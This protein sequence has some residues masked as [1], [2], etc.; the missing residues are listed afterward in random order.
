M[1]TV[2]S[3][4]CVSLC[5]KTTTCVGFSSGI[6]VDAVA[7][8][9]LIFRNVSDLSETDQSRIM[10]NVESLLAETSRSAARSTLDSDVVLIA[11]NEQGEEER[12]RANSDVLRRTSQGFEGLLQNCGHKNE[13]P[14]VIVG[15]EGRTRLHSVRAVRWFLEVLHAVDA[16]RA[17]GE[18][19]VP[20]EPA[21]H[22]RTSG[23]KS[24]ATPAF[25]TLVAACEIADCWDAP[26]VFS[27]ASDCVMDSV[28]LAREGTFSSMAR[29]IIKLLRLI[30]QGVPP[31]MGMTQ[32]QE[33]TEQ[34]LATFVPTNRLAA[35]LKSFEMEQ[36]SR[37]INMLKDEEVVLTPLALQGRSPL[38]RGWQ[39]DLGQ[40]ISSGIGMSEPTP[41]RQNYP[42]R[43]NKQGFRVGK[44]YSSQ[45]NTW[46][47]HAS[48]NRAELNASSRWTFQIQL[49]LVPPNPKEVEALHAQAFGL[50]GENWRYNPDT[51]RE[52]IEACDRLEA[53]ELSLY[54]SNVGTS[55]GLLDGASFW[56][57]EADGPKIM[58]PG[59]ALDGYALPPCQSLGFRTLK[60]PSGMLLS[61]LQSVQIGGTVVISKLQRQFEVLARWQ[62]LTGRRCDRSIPSRI[63]SSVKQLLSDTNLIETVV[64]A[65]LTQCPVL[66]FIP[67]EARRRIASTTVLQTIVTTQ[68]APPEQSPA[69]FELY[70]AMMEF[71][72]RRLDDNHGLVNRSVHA[73][74]RDSVL[75][76]LQR[77]GFA[78]LYAP[79]SERALLRMAVDW[80]TQPH[81]SIEDKEVVMDTIHFAALPAFTLLHYDRNKHIQAALLRITNGI[82]PEG[83]GVCFHSKVVRALNA[84]QLGVST[85]DV[86]G[87][88]WMRSDQIVRRLDA[89][90]LKKLAGAN[91]QRMQSL[92]EQN[93]TLVDR[94]SEAEDKLSRIEAGTL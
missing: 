72:A 79:R 7:M 52:Q 93:Q 56:I 65:K 43:L 94:L 78:R 81:R 42:R 28:A 87:R 69:V 30:P 10:S 66:P 39:H 2:R 48:Q 73:L 19:L 25:E 47:T 21:A 36:V 49:S 41:K 55:T 16:H 71:V 29:G 6:M 33:K 27:A 5:N 80:A 1:V 76:V 13:I 77:P 45:A 32:L 51:P 67:A 90:L 58:L 22:I 91:A 63:V 11:A 82:R 70:V 88:V 44:A 68:M 89:A 60:L 12:V 26:A 64:K 20:T 17:A 3:L 34:A 61:R 9:E 74:D 57:Q 35:L 75:R 83:Q 85:H 15:A 50:F 18:S 92:C 14:I 31:S 38:A 53:G 24:D 86:K 54:L 62:D 84:K 59:C 23:L 46:E 40:R 37:V 8:R 4:P